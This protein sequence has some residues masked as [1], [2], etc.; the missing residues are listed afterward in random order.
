VGIEDDPFD[1][2]IYVK[3]G[4]NVTVLILMALIWNLV[5]PWL[6]DSPASS[7]SLPAVPAGAFLV[8]I[9]VS[10]VCTVLTVT[11]I[12]TEAPPNQGQPSRPAST[13]SLGGASATETTGSDAADRINRSPMIARD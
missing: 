2:P 9:F 1:V 8:A 4:Y 5:G 13:S 3:V 12:R 7:Q 11:W 10:A 6:F